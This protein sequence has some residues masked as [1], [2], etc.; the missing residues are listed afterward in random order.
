MGNRARL[1]EAAADLF[2]RRGYQATSV[3]DVLA[4]TGVARSNFYYHFASKLELA[5]EV[6]GYW[7]AEYE[8]NVVEPTL[9]DLSLSPAERLRRMFACAAGTQDCAAGHSGCPLGS[10]AVELAQHEG[11]VQAALSDYFRRLQERLADTIAEGVAR[12][13]YQATRPSDAAQLALSVLEGALLLSRTHQSPN[14][15]SS[16]G[17]AFVTLLEGHEGD[18]QHLPSHTDVK[19]SLS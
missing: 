16:A 13:E 5:R 1:I 14:L 17:L 4:A 6:V 9:G 10:L 19:N 11:E 8:R 2:Y 3:E 7:I 12:R 18:S 15:V